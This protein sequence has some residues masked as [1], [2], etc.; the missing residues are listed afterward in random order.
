MHDK[1]Q[2]DAKSNSTIENNSED[3]DRSVKRTRITYDS[4]TVDAHHFQSRSN[5]TRNGLKSV[6][7][8]PVEPIDGHDFRRD[9]NE[10]RGIDLSNERIIKTERSS[11]KCLSRSD[12]KE[13]EF[14]RDRHFT[15]TN[16]NH[17][18]KSN[19]FTST[20]SH[21]TDR[22]KSAKNSSSDRKSVV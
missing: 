18:S 15:S 6:V 9:L 21:R 12:T 10:K 16:T 8:V 11:S 14:S 13:K 19:K 17:T 5:K 4:T 20:S 3:E 2:A 7:A 22:D 1:Q